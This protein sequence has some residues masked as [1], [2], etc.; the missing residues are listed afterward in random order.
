MA[1]NVGDFSAARMRERDFE[2]KGLAEGEEL[3]SNILSQ[4]FALLRST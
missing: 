3:T 4:D 2:K 1:A